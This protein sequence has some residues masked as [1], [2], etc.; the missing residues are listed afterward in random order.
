MQRFGVFSDDL[1]CAWT[2][3]NLFLSPR[4]DVSISI[5]VEANTTTEATNNTETPY[6]GDFVITSLT[7]SKTALG[8]V[9]ANIAFELR[10]SFPYFARLGRTPCA[11]GICNYRL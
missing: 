11:Q 3:A 7:Y 2:A 6:L 5:Q 10:T 1:D 4:Y 9:T 8:K